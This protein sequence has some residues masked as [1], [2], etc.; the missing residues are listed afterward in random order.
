MRFENGGAPSGTAYYNKNEDNISI[1]GDPDSFALV[2]S[3][4]SLVRNKIS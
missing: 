3:G 2:I 4:H 1:E